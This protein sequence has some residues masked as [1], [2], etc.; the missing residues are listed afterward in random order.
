V[1]TI[2]DVARI[3]GV[4]VST[5]SHVVNGTRPVS[6]AT[7]ARI[8]AAI[9]ETGYSQ[10]GVARALRRSK[11]DSVGLVISDT[12]QPVFADMVRGVEHEAR[13]AGF[14]L[15][16]SNSAEDR[17]RQAES[18]QALRERRVDGLM[19]AP[20]AGTDHSLVD[21]MRQWRVPLVL[22]DRLTAPDVDQVGVENHDSMQQLVEHLIVRAHRR[23]G[24]VSGDLRVPVLDERK[25]GY[26]DAFAAH[27]VPLDET[28][29]V[30]GTTQ[31]DDT[32][33]TVRP[34][35]LGPDRPTAFVGASMIISLGV[36]RALQEEGLEIPDDM[37]FAVFDEPAYADLFRPRLTSV[38]QPAFEIGREA[39]RLLLRRLSDPD[40]PPRTERLRPALIHRE[41]CGCPAGTTAEWEVVPTGHQS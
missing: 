41:S 2:S 14:T 35:L 25:Q 21:Q 20:V 1:A 29:I 23:I 19:V 24:Y 13:L 38:V 36:M 11:T 3:A 33:A 12:G 6:D 17:D 15:L 40:A 16:L 10:D 8:E 7:R 26:L 39:M 18:I 31:V 9:D 4:S 5:V 22:V 27:G 28:L 30:Q 34:L 32:A 37:A